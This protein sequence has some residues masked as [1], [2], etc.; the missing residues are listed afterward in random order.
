M[1]RQVE[2]YSLPDVAL[3]CDCSLATA[4][5]RVAAAQQKISRKLRLTE[6]PD[7]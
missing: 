1:L 7:A 4:K 5:R 3:S 2:G 6:A